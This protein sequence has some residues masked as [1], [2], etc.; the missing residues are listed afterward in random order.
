MK[1]RNCVKGFTNK[2]G[3]EKEYIKLDMINY[4]VA[5]ALKKEGYKIQNIKTLDGR[6]WGTLINW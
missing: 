6:F 5:D 3:E 4:E 1:V 2:K